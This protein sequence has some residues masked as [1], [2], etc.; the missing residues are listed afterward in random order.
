[1]LLRTTGWKIISKTVIHRWY[2]CMYEKFKIMYK[3]LEIMNI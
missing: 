1:M 2:N 3:Q